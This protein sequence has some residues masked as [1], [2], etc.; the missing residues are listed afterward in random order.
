MLLGVGTYH[1]EEASGCRQARPGCC[2]YLH[3]ASLILRA[4]ILPISPI[5][6]M[7]TTVSPML[8]GGEPRAQ[9]TRLAQQ[10]ASFRGDGTRVRMREFARF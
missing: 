8:A 2:T 5:P 9:H 10:K 3:P 6:M 1:M 7:P 4:Y